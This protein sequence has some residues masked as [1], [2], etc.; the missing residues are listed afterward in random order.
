MWH[1]LYLGHTESIHHVQNLVLI[2]LLSLHVCW[3]MGQSWD[4]LDKLF[5]SPAFKPCASLN[6]YEHVTAHWSAVSNVQASILA[7]YN[8]N[9][10]IFQWMVMMITCNLFFQYC[11]H[12]ITTYSFQPPQE[13]VLYYIVIINTLSQEYNIC[14]VTIKQGEAKCRTRLRTWWITL[15]LKS[16]PNVEDDG[17]GRSG[18]GGSGELWGRKLVWVRQSRLAGRD[19]C[20]VGQGCGDPRTE[21]KQDWSEAKRCNHRAWHKKA[22]LSGL[23]TTTY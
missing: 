11:E 12:E 6:F 4:I 13:N 14:F 16:K 5:T 7:H 20:S 1:L 22:M 8:V 3:E 2:L 17:E 15:G 18:D 21:E 19:E 9:L 10:N 23:R